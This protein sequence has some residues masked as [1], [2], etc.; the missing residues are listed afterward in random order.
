MKKQIVRLAV[1][2]LLF[3]T[4]FSLSSAAGST[5]G[6]EGKVIVKLNEGEDGKSLQLQLANLQKLR[7]CVGIQDLQGKV[8]FVEYVWR[9]N[10]YH[11]SLNI[12]GMPAGTYFLWVKNKQVETHRSFEFN[13]NGITFFDQEKEAL[14]AEPEAV[15][16]GGNSAEEGKLIARVTPAGKAAL[17]VQL[18]NLQRQPLTLRLSAVGESEVFSENVRNEHA[19]AKKLNFKGMTPGSYFLSIETQGATLVAFFTLSGDDG[20]RLDS[21]QKLERTAKAEGISGN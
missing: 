1:L 18:A 8:W 5:P 11:K 14:E 16:T 10:G 12:K 20:L 3:T 9:E 21:V 6:A 15:F 2:A 13:G 4:Q 7:T 17:D 19:F